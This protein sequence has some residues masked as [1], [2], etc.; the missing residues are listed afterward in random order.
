MFKPSPATEDYNHEVACFIEN[1]IKD[2]GQ[3]ALKISALAKDILKHHKDPQALSEGLN[4]NEL[5]F[6]QTSETQKEFSRS[7]KEFIS[8]QVSGNSRE[9][10]ED[11]QV[12]MQTQ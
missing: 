3:S 2:R 1:F 5:S 7:L 10:R 11:T 8:K 4:R 12:A 9:C 6:F